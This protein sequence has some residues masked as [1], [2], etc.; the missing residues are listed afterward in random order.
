[1]NRISCLFLLASIV[2]AS[3]SQDPQPAASPAPEVKANCSYSRNEKDPLGK[4]IRVTDEA[5]FIS[6]NFPESD[7]KALARDQ[8][9]VKGYLSCL[10]VDT[11]LGIYF[12][13]NIYS[14]NAF[15]TYGGIKRGNKIVFTLKSGKIVDVPFARTFSGNTNLSVGF[16]EYSSYAL[17]SRSNAASL[18]S[19]EIQSVR[20]Y[21]WKMD[22]A[23]TV[24]NPKVFMN[25]LP[26]VQ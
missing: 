9:L 3:C 15:E 7:V 8:E 26:C 17:L 14:D 22:E 11:L 13:F 2:F 25:L 1:M 16:T 12:S 5:K 19:E 18:Q 23:Y 24:V 10:N 6:L 20:V 21:W 4:Q